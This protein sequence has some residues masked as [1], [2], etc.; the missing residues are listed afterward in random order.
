MACI[1]NLIS[2]LIHLNAQ[3]QYRSQPFSPYR[4][5]AFL[6]P[7]AFL[8]KGP[9]EQGERIGA[10]VALVEHAIGQ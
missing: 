5:S 8:R 2:Y 6:L 10:L 4:Q 7:F 3:C 1:V 9:S